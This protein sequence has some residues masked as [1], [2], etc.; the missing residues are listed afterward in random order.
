MNQAVD[1]ARRVQANPPAPTQGAITEMRTEVAKRT[2]P[3]TRIINKFTGNSSVVPG[4][5]PNKSQ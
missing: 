3:I 2:N 1:N 4:E 5:N